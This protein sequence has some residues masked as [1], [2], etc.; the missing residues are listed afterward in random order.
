MMIP[1]KLSRICQAMLDRMAPSSR[2]RAA[3][4]FAVA[5]RKAAKNRPMSMVVESAYARILTASPFSPSRFPPGQRRGDRG[6][7]GADAEQAEQAEGPQVV[8]GEAGPGHFR[9]VPDGVERVLY[10]VGQS[11][12]PQDGAD[13]ADDQRR[14]GVSEG[15]DSDLG[16]Q[17]GADHGELRESGGLDA[18]L[19]RRVTLKHE[20]EDARQRQQKREGRQEREV[21]QQRDEITCLVIAE[22]LE[23]G[24]DERG[25]RWRC[26]HA[27]TVRMPR[28]NGF[29]KALTNATSG[30]AWAPDFVLLPAG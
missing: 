27:S 19:Q 6:G 18:G 24:E 22:F 16:L 17:L 3:T 11:L 30:P 7:D 21:G 23:D 5:I 4:V 25:T 14:G 13:D 26:C 10:R 29:I 9:N 12:P 2:S 20:A 1:A 28:S 8:G 15:R